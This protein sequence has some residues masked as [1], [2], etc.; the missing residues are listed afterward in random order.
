MIFPPRLAVLAGAVLLG[1]LVCGGICAADTPWPFPAELTDQNTSV[2]FDLDTTW[3]YV[4]GVAPG[5]VGRVELADPSDP[6]ALSGQVRLPVAKF[7]TKDDDRDDTIREVM[8]EAQYPWVSVTFGRLSE[9][10]HPRR[11]QPEG[12]CDGVMAAKLK[13]R[14][15]ER[16]IP[17]P[18]R[19]TLKD[20]RYTA[21][22]DLTVN[23]LSYG[24]EDPSI[25]I[26]RV[27]PTVDVHYRVELGT[28]ASGTSVPKK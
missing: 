4:H 7:D 23:W 13:I 17:L 25:L 12:A 2:R 18:F 27:K 5:V 11:L 10:C 24:V 16:E 1:S 26:A 14:S 6:L 9:T 3:H 8:A 15:T 20:G 28:G 22:G 19:I 21:E